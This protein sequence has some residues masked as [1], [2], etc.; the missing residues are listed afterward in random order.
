MS[1]PALKHR[2]KRSATAANPVAYREIYLASAVERVRLIRAGIPAVTV[3]R[4]IRDLHFEQGDFL[5]AL[6]L[7][8][9]TVNRKVAREE[10]LSSDD[11]ARVLG[12]AELVGQVE[13]MVE[14]SGNSDGFD[15]AAW[16]SKWLREP[17]P[18]F[19]GTR[20]IDLLDTIVGQSLVGRA[21]AQVQSGAYA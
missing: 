3:K 2:Q 17:L 7:K 6:N 8:T 18:A 16:L 4:M 13:S 12:I 15:A 10:L 20:P 1:E 21:L 5:R 14:E 11:S 9:A 19:A